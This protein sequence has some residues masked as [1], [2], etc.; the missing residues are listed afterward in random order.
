MALADF[1]DSDSNDAISSISGTEN[2]D[3]NNRDRTAPTPAP[4]ARFMNDF[5]VRT[6]NRPINEAAAAN[7]LAQLRNNQ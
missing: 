5:Q 3:N 6:I 1:S 2:R 4:M 7:I